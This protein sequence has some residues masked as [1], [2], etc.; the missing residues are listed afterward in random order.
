MIHASTSVAWPPGEARR[1]TMPAMRASA[2]TIATARTGTSVMRISGV[3]RR[4][5]AAS[6]A[7]TPANSS[8][9]AAS[10]KGRITAS[11]KP[12]SE[13]TSMKALAGQSPSQLVQGDGVG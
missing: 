8:T 12:G 13:P 5:R 2:W 4:I 6:T 9:V 3:P 10:R 11:T 7:I 1:V